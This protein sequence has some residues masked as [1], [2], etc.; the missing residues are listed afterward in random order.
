MRWDKVTF[1]DVRTIMLL[2]INISNKDFE[3]SVCFVGADFCTFMDTGYSRLIKKIT[4]EVPDFP[5]KAISKNFALATKPTR[6]SPI[7][8]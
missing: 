4:G 8:C 6:P 7:N 2:D 3:Q 1:S 5:Y